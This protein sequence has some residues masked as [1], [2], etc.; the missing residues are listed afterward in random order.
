MDDES[1]RRQSRSLHG[2]GPLDLAGELEETARWCRERAV[3]ADVYG[4]GSFLQSFEAQVA[5]ML[6]FEAARLLPSGTMAQQIAAR[7]HCERSG[8]RSFAM[9]PTCHLE[10]H[11]ERGYGRLH[12]LHA[13]LLGPRGAPL[14]AEHLTAV[15]ER[16][17]ALIVELPAREIGG[18]LP[19]F[20][21]L[22]ALKEA[23][24]ARGIPLHL[25]GARLWECGA[26]YDRPLSEITAGF[27]TAYVSFYKGIGALPGCMLLGSRSFVDEAALWQRRCGGNLF[28]LTQ[29]AAS[30]ARQLSARLD[31]MPALLEGARRLAREL[32]E[33][34]GVTVLP[35]EPQVNLFHVLLATPPERALAARRRVAEERGIWAF[36]GLRESGLPN[37]S[38]FE[39]YVGEATLS[40]PIPEIR[41]AMAALLE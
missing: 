1:L 3:S 19:S 30:A 28:T 34:P 38:R 22:S 29:S 16:I 36:G 35:E 12:G 14:L 8:C 13:Q 17:A 21:Q 39:I 31:R 26:A 33:I 24:A 6:G 27:S 23:A 20:E 18:Q 37:T 4:Q 41:A 5:Q 15:R 9:H 7:V 40:V 32:R 11:E 25:D 2:H 10:L